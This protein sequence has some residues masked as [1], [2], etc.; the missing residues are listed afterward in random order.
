MQKNRGEK[1]LFN[2]EFILPANGR[3]TGFWEPKNLNKKPKKA[4]LWN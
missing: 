1:K 3:L 4:S 2:S